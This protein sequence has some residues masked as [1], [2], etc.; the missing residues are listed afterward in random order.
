MKGHLEPV[1]LPSTPTTPT[2]KPLTAKPPHTPPKL[3]RKLPKE[4][5]D[6][7]KE[8]NYLPA[9]PTTQLPRAWKPHE[10]PE[11]LQIFVDHVPMDLIQQLDTPTNITS[12]PQ[13]YGI[14]DHPFILLLYA[15]KDDNTSTASTIHD[16]Y[17]WLTSWVVEHDILRDPRHD[18][19]Q[20]DL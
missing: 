12:K 15:G 4:F 8:T 20:P 7:D 14:P 16:T 1:H 10:V 17:P 9:S 2:P 6:L 11:W 13:D 18:I 19:L 3:P 5:L